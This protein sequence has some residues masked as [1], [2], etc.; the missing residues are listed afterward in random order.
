MLRRIS[1]GLVVLLAA[2]SPATRPHGSHPV[3]SSTSP[4]MSRPR[5]SVASSSACGLRPPRTRRYRHVVWIWFENHSYDQLIGQP[6]A[7]YVN[8][9]ATRCA[10]ESNYDDVTHPSLP[11]YLAA[12]AGTTGGVSGDCSPDQCPQPEASLFSQL[13]GD[14]RAY[15]EAMPAPCSR[16]D[17]G[18]Y[19]PRHNPAVYFTRTA[20]QCARQDLP[21][22]SFPDP[23]PAFTFITPDLCDDMHDCPVRTG[24]AW[25]ATWLPKLLRTPD[26]LAGTTAVFITWDEAADGASHVPL[27]IVAPTVRPG[28]RFT[29]R[30]DHYTL[31]RTTEDLLGVPPLGAAATAPTLAGQL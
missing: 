7:P 27:L 31:L 10:L 13:G 9:L 6:Q 4:S 22:S 25:L 24:D 12:V 21:L 8:R 18:R 5:P 29:T 26:Y 19:A 17:Y 23:L 3:T 14:W 2:C 11:N 1:L 16:S 20:A 30:A 15:A 28:E